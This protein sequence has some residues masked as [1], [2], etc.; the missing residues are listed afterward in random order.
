[1]ADFQLPLDTGNIA[2]DPPAPP[3]R[4][5][6]WEQIPEPSMFSN[7]GLVDDR[8][9]AFYQTGGLIATHSSG[10]DR[11]SIWDAIKRREVYATS[12]QRT[13]L[14]FELLNAT[15]AQVPVA[16]GAEVVM[17]EN[18]RF[19]VRAAGSFKQQPGCPEYATRG[20]TP[21]RLER[22]CRGE[23]YNP[24]DERRLITRIEVIRIR[25]QSY[26]D[27]PVDALI[28]DPWQ[29]FDCAPD[30]LG[31]AIEFEDRDFAQGQRDALYYVR[32][33]EE[34]SLAVNGALLDC[35]YNKAGDCVAINPA[36]KSVEDDRLAPIEERAWS[37]PI[38]V[39]YGRAGYGAKND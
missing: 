21:E 12:G 36:P 24:S 10:R 22:L 14:W 19:S 3:A 9:G 27:E 5:I 7:D 35:T 25:P 15:D 4:S 39:N 11:H 2:P 28:E 16:M 26:P 17:T 38:F 13:L 18:P 23:C 33:I 32:A 34:P 1:M 29:S 8:V 30:P 20:L 6:P 37:S 31:C